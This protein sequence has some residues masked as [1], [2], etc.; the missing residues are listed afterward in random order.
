MDL[1]FKLPINLDDMS[2]N[3]DD[4]IAFV[5][6]LN[7]QRIYAIDDFNKQLLTNYALI[8]RESIIRRIKGNIIGSLALERD[9]ETIYYS[10]LTQYKW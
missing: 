8:K 5:D 7:T 10:I 6:W 4:Y 9:L 1:V 2:I 3:P